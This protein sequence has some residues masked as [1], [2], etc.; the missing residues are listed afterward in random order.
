MMMNCRGLG[1]VREEPPKAPPIAVC[2]LPLPLCSHPY[3][4][5]EGKFMTELH[6]NI[7]LVR[8]Q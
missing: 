1:W 2:P 6:A 4:K 7:L 3:L 8:Q 5:L